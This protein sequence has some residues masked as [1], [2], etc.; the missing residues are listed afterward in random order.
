MHRFPY[1]RV[2]QLRVALEDQTRCSACVLTGVWAELCWEREP[3]GPGGSEWVTKF[4]I[5]SLKS[6]ANVHLF[7][8]IKRA[9]QRWQR[10]ASGWLAS[11]LLA[12]YATAVSS[13]L[14][15]NFFSEVF[16]SSVGDQCGITLKKIHIK[17]QKKTLLLNFSQ[18]FFS[19]RSASLSYF[20]LGKFHLTF[21]HPPATLLV[22]WS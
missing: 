17:R 2:V 15:F 5:A 21:R 6:H 1:M 14:S 22:K 7:P 10:Q 12:S 20:S 8:T 16:V 11:G 4:R 13:F 18:L 3:G 19:P 9:A